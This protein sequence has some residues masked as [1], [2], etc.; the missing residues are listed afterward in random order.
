MGRAAGF[1]PELIKQPHY[2]HQSALPALYDDWLT[3]DEIL[4]QVLILLFL[5]A[6][7][8]LLGS[9][10]FIYLEVRIF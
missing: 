5:N 1:E 10:T 9:L 4:V 8:W 6:T 3:Y 2:Q 7:A